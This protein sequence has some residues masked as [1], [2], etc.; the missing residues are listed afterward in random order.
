[1]SDD[2]VFIGLYELRLTSS[3]YPEQ[4]DV[5]RGEEQVGYIRAEGM[6]AEARVPAHG[7][8]LVYDERIDGYGSFT[9]RER[10]KHLRRATLAIDDH[11]L[12]AALDKMHV[13]VDEEA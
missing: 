11:F 9:Q 4:Y 1:M 6:I 3:G 12:Q 7:G 13:S 10:L 5:Y 8:A 2:S